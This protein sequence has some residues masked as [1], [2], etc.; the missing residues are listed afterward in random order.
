MV[1]K[2]YQVLVDPQE[3]HSLFS[4]NTPSVEISS[5][6]AE[7]IDN[8]QDNNTPSVQIKAITKLRNGG[9][10]VEMDNAESAKWIKSNNIANQFLAALDIP[11]PTWHPH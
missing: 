6:L 7:I 8:I 5:K 11:P 4:N 1:V 10:I 2:E 3:G 9:L